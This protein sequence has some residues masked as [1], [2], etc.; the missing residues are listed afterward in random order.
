MQNIKPNYIKIYS[1][2]IHK[3]FPE[4]MD[5]CK[6]ILQKESL[7]ELDILELNQKIFGNSELDAELFNQ[8]HRAYNETAIKQILKYQSKNKCNNTE[9][10]RYFKLSRNTVTKWKK[11]FI[12][13][14][15]NFKNRD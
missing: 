6:N 10:A 3:K 14:N 15:N 7:S 11:L 4:K 2:I 8:R 5:Q 9:L 13:K 1:D 12:N